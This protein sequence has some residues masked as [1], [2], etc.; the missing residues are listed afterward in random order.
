[1][2]GINV[3]IIIIIIKVTFC[4]MFDCLSVSNFTYK[5]LSK[6]SQKFYQKMH[7]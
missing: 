7:L 3:I 6:S 2:R 5:L 4:L 1:M